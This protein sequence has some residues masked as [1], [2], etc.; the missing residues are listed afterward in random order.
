MR[1]L[2]ILPVVAMAAGADDTMDNALATRHAALPDRIYVVGKNGRIAWKAA[3]GPFGFRPAE[4]WR[5]VM[6]LLGVPVMRL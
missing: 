1:A 4:A 2:A 3:P 6:K 5:A